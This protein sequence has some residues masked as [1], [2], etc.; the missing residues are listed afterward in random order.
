MLT[1]INPYEIIEF[2]YVRYF[3]LTLLI[4]GTFGNI[5]NICIF[6]CSKFRSVSC[7]WYFLI[8]TF[9]N[10]IALYIGCLT[11][12]LSTFNINPTTPLSASLYCKFRS[13]F[14]YGSLSTSI[15][16]IIGACIDRWASSS[17]N[18]QIR[19]ISTIKMAKRILHLIYSPILYSYNGS[20]QL[21]SSDCI[22]LTPI[23]Q[24]YISAGFFLTYSFLPCCLMLIFGLMTIENVRTSRRR[25]AQI[26]NTR[27]T[28]IQMAFMLF[29]QVICSIIISLPISLQSMYNVLTRNDY[30]SIEQQ[31]LEN[32]L[33]TLFVT[34]T[35]MN[36]AIS[37]YIFTL[38][39]KI[40]RKE[41]KK[42]LC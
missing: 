36:S 10:F 3:C 32:F 22:T 30:K 2:Y 1:S 40:F 21:P 20:Y 9:E 5:V 38:T 28:S 12:F 13:Y 41:L 11:R 42:F 35:F 33:N 37:F 39:G 23:W 29:M 17:S 18:V 25:I 26:Q 14:T 16:L 27:K 31:Q 7:S 24:L 8:G 15:W 34:F 6:T 19:S 4:F